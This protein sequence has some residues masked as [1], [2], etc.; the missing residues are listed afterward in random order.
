MEIPVFDRMIREIIPDI[1]SILNTNALT[2]PFPVYVPK[3]YKKKNEAVSCDHGK[4]HP[5]GH[6][7]GSIDGAPQDVGPISKR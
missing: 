6:C 2:N 5:A 4:T 3:A 1:G 7:I